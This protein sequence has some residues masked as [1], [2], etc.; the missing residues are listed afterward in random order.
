M[1]LL[2]MIHLKHGARRKL[3]S[4]LDLAIRLDHL[5]SRNLLHESH[6]QEIGNLLHHEQH[7]LG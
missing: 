1:Y 7:A 6:I 5:L 2:C 4:K 3:C